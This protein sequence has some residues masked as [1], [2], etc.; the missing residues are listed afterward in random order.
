MILLLHNFCCREINEIKSEHL[1]AANSIESYLNNPVNAFRLIKRLHTDWE[2]LEESVESER[3][4]TSW[5]PNRASLTCHSENVIIIDLTKLLSI[6]HPSGASAATFTIDYLE[7]MA[8][9]RQ[10]LSFPTMEDFVGTT[11]AMTRLQQTYQL[12]VGE[13]AS[14][15]LNG[16]KYG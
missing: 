8:S 12:D 1:T 7:A 9:H 5:Y 6:L 10:N 4:R 14:G 13:L 2:T 11:L 15:M 16:V 3:S